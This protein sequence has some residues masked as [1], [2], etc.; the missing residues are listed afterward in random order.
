MDLALGITD[1][2]PTLTMST[3]D[4]IDAVKRFKSRSAHEPRA[5][6]TWAHVS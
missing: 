3:E 5:K 6:A 2:D 1:P 4:L